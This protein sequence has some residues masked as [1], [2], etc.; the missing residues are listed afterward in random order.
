MKHPL[1]AISLACLT[2]TAQAQAPRL[3]DAN[4][5]DPARLGWMKGSP[6]PAD[7]MIR[8]ADGTGYRFPQLRWTFANFRQFVPTTNIWRGNGAPSA[9]PRAERSDIDAL[10]FTPLGRSE[11]MTWAQSLDANYTDA[12]VV[13]HKGRIVYERY[14]GV[15]TP[16]QPHIVQS[17]TKSFFGT[18]GATLVA[19]GKLEASAPVSRYIPEIKDSAFGDATV[20]QVLDMTTGI[21]FSEAYAD[22][23]AEIWTYARAGGVLPRP[24]GYAGPQ[25]FYEY[26]ATVKKDGE[27]GKAFAYKTVNSDVMGWL[28][29]R[30]TGQGVGEVLSECP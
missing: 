26:I 9:L 14:M 7:K 11:P 16:Q 12:I 18:L 17:V 8:Y 4:E 15:M 22:P 2:M 30:A 20:R 6:P 28:I 24:P 3:P 19:E 21:Q 29:R 27:H 23:K 1:A 13:L 10:V 25:N 5:S